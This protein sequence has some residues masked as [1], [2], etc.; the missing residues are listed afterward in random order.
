MNVLGWSD[1]GMKGESEE[2]TGLIVVNSRYQ[3]V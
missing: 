2:Y 3:E 1:L